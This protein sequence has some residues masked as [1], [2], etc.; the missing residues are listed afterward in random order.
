MAMKIR[1]DDFES[2]EVFEATRK[3]DPAHPP[4]YHVD[5]AKL[6]RIRARRKAGRRAQR[7]REQREFLEAKA[8]VKNHYEYLK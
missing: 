8:G 7:R 6:E 1:T 3:P 4:G 5:K 2:V